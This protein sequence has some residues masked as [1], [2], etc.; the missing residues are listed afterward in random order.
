MRGSENKGVR[1][2]NTVL[3]KS[4][5]KLTQKSN[6]GKKQHFPHEAKATLKKNDVKPTQEIFRNPLVKA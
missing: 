6:A 4:N 5:A 3:A 2:L 1:V